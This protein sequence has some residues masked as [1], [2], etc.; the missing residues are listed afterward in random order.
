ML[1][2]C[3]PL[4]LLWLRQAWVTWT[5]FFLMRLF[6]EKGVSYFCLFICFSFKTFLLVCSLLLFTWSF[7]C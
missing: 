7:A 6:W 1:G 2:H 3:A 5:F 4:G